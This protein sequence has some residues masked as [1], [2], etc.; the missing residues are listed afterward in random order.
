MWTLFSVLETHVY[1]ILRMFNLNAFCRDNGVRSARE[2]N[3]F[4][5]VGDSVLVGGGGGGGDGGRKAGC[6]TSSPSPVRAG[7]ITSFLEVATIWGLAV[8]EYR[9]MLKFLVGPNSNALVPDTPYLY[10]HIWSYVELSLFTPT[11]H[12]AP[13]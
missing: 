11:I 8:V 13:V 9:L 6:G 2:G 10:G 4:T 1:S 7:S 5:G 12:Y 3:V